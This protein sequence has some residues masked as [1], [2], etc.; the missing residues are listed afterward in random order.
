[1]TNATNDAAIFI[2][3]KALAERW[4]WNPDSIYVLLT[5]RTLPIPAIRIGRS[6]RFKLADVLAYEAANT[7]AP[8]TANA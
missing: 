2:T 3:P 4:A 1:M 7:V 6:V 5:R 8:K